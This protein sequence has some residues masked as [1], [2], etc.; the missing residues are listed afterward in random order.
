[1]CGRYTLSSPPDLVGELVG[2]DETPRLRPRYN[3]A[4]TQLVPAVR[5]DPGGGRRLDELRWGLIPHWAK[6]ASIGNRM[7]NARVETAASKPAFRQA[8]RRR[9]CLLPADGFY[10]WKPR[11]G[12]KQPYL[13]RH[14]EGRPFAFAALWERWADPQGGDVESCTILTTDASETLAQI[15]ERMPVILPPAAYE[16]W[17]DPGLDDVATLERL[18]ARPDADELVFHPVSRWVNSPANEGPRCVEPI[19]RPEP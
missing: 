7:I 13:V 17:L 1:M 2:L 8:F 18:V 12:A 11:R 14:R 15:H 16:A 9:R 5:Q 10:E 19:A 6:E 4:P 3:I